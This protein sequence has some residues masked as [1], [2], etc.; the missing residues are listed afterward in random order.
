M[1]SG[2]YNMEVAGINEDGPFM[3]Y[4]VIYNIKFDEIRGND[5]FDFK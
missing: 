1:Q 3:G 4:Q 5:S 2:G